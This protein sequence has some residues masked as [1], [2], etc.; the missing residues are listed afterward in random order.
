MNTERNKLNS[1][2]NAFLLVSLAEFVIFAFMARAEFIDKIKPLG[3]ITE[4]NH[5]LNGSFYLGAALFFGVSFVATLIDIA[6]KS[7]LR[8]LNGIR[9]D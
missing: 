3:N 8:S 7:V 5:T 1:P 2:G 6:E 4:T 9:L